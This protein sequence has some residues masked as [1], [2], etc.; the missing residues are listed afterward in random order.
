EFGRILRHAVLNGVEVYAY[1]SQ[2]IG[3]KIVLGEKVK[4][5][6]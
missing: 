2:F 5:K 1:S 3:N 4:V 6:L